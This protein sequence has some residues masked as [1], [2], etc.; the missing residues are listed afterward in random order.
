MWI[1]SE[2]GVD[3]KPGQRHVVR[4]FV[5]NVGEYIVRRFIDVILHEDKLVKL[6]PPRGAGFISPL[7]CYG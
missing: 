1:C 7:L 3:G 2:L 5:E 4:V 6:M